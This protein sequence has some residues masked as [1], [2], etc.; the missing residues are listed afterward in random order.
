M[1]GR[2][3][4]CGG[5]VPVFGGVA[6]DLCGLTAGLVVDEISLVADVP[7]GIF[8]PDLE[9]ALAQVGTGYTLGHWPQSMDLSTVGGWLACRGAGQYS[10][11]Y[12]KIE[13]MV[14]GLEVV[15]ADGRIVHTE[16]LGPASRHRS[17]PDPALRGQR[18]H[19]RGHHPGPPAH[20]PGAPGPRSPGLWLRHLCRWARSLSPHPPSGGHAGRAAP[21]RRRPSRTGT[22]TKPTTNVLIVLDEADPA[23][24]G[25]HHGG[26]RRGVPRPTALDV[27][28]VER[29]LGAPQR[30]VGPRSAVAGRRLRRHGRGGGLVG[31]PAR[32][33]PR[34]HCGLG[35]VCRGHPGRLGPPVATPTP[36]APASTSPLPDARADD[37]A[38]RSTTWRPGTP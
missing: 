32:S 16:G 38:A 28:L 2:S 6:L 24:A 5:S 11:R 23:R 36:T 19:A 3:G 10:T 30:R 8:G 31:R 34:C 21:L 7:A 29:W 33:A 35:S 14:V 17:Q 20:P 12:G 18:R 9:A 26:G 1:A 4:V 15:L 27:A 22:S 37:A 13:D 25:R